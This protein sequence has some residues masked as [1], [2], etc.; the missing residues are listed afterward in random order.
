MKNTRVSFL[1]IELKKTGYSFTCT[2]VYEKLKRI[3]YKQ[4]PATIFDINFK[5]LIT[6][7]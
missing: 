7:K 1:I 3:F 4:Q 5:N 2:K 6:V